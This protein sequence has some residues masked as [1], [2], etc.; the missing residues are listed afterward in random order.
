[1]RAQLGLILAATLL[2][3]CAS[4]VQTTSGAGYLAARPEFQPPA[5]NSVERAVYDAAKA[6][7]AL[8]FPAR[9]GLA[10]IQGGRLSAIPPEEGDKWLA[11]AKDL[12]TTYGEFVP[13]S[14]LVADM[15]SSGR[16]N[17][18]VVDKIRIGAAR[19][20]VDAVL[21]YEVVRS[22]KD[23]GSV[24]S[25]ADLTI[26]GSFLIP[27]RSIEGQATATAILLDVRNGYPYGTA[28]ST[29]QQT[30]FV[31]NSGSGAAARDLAEQAS[32]DAVGKLTTDIKQMVA[33]LKSELDT[34]ELQR[35]RATPA[36]SPSRRAQPAPR[37]GLSS[38]TATPGRQP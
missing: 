23:R 16:A 29:A 9:L 21:V 26:I 36:A 35:L 33:R 28:T 37:T 38:G 20:H 13:I 8:R 10:R 24:L 30:G 3:G 25:V 6:E 14:P 7:P 32:V 11:L 4:T 2:A 19:Q 27:S 17:D 5:G 22:D 34:R 31:P 12:G 18:T 15:A 1:M